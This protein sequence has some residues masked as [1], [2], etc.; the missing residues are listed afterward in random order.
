MIVLKRQSNPEAPHETFRDDET[1]K[2]AE[3]LGV[4][5]ET[6]AFEL[7]EYGVCWIPEIVAFAVEDGA[8]YSQIE[9]EWAALEWVWG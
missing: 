8:N 4:D 9:G 2:V 3:I 6:V 1:A 7:E 5:A